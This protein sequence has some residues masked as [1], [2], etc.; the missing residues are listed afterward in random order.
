MIQGLLQHGASLGLTDSNGCNAHDLSASAATTAI[1]D[2]EVE[3]R[4]EADAAPT[5]SHEIVQ[6]HAEVVAAPEMQMASDYRK[7]AVTS[8]A[9]DQAHGDM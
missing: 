4:R 9:P 2:A 6:L 7:G 8:V 1:L 5:I 3:R